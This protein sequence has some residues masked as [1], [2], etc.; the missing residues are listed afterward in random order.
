MTPD[1]SRPSSQGQFT[2]LWKL[3][4][5]GLTPWLLVRNVVG[6]IGSNNFLGRASE[7]AFDFLLAVSIDFVHGNNVRSVRFTQCGTPR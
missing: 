3:G 6:E 7:L 1:K 5:G 2:S 4:V